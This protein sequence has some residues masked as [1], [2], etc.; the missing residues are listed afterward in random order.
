MD[1]L[2]NYPS[3]IK[4]PPGNSKQIVTSG[5]FSHKFEI[6]EAVM[7]NEQLILLANRTFG[8]GK[9]NHTVTNQTIDFIE[10]FMGKYV[11]G[12]VTF[13]KIQ[14]QDGTFHE[15]IG[16]C[17]AEGAMKGLSIHCA[18][19]M[20]L[21]KYYYKE[22]FQCSFPDLQTEILEPCAQSTPFLSH[23][24]DEQKEK[25][26][27]IVKLKSLN[28]EKRQIIAQQ[29][30]ARSKSPTE[31]KEQ[32]IPSKTSSDL[33]NHL[34]SNSTNHQKQQNNVQKEQDS[35]QV[36]NEEEFLRMERKRKQME[37]QAEYK[38][39]MKEKEHQKFYDNKKLNPKY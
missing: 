1:K 22:D 38:R 6:K 9:W 12:C 37:K 19:I 4:I 28:D 29:Q 36:L 33:K 20:P 23:K 21:R 26:D 27:N 2:N 8:E 31:Q 11:C 13:V 14:L 7:L 35:I 5:I 24:N 16:Y 17:H 34:Q 30:V 39:L 25:S 32:Y 18:R 3:C 10:A 15:D